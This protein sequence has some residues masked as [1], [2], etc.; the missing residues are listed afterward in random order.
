VLTPMIA[1]KNFSTDFGI[2]WPEGPSSLYI[3][4]G[5][6]DLFELVWINRS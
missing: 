5:L 1:A 6:D 4:E 3:K 2:T